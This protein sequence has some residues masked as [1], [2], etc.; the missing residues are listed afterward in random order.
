M[1]KLY[2]RLL[3]VPSLIY[4]FLIALVGLLLFL[5]HYPL[6]ILGDLIRFSFPLLVILLIII[7]AI[8][9]HRINMLH[10]SQAITPQTPVEVQLL[11][12][13]TQ[14]RQS[15]KHFKQKQALHQREQLERLELFAHEIKN[16]LAILKS[17]A[18]NQNQV[19]STTVKR[20]VQQADYYLTL[21]LTDERLAMNA[22]DFTFQWINLEK[23]VNE[24]LQQNSSRFISKQLLPNLTG[25][26][27][28][29]ILSDQKWLRFCITQV[30][31][32][33][34]KYSKTNST[35][36]ITWQNHQLLIADKGCGISPQDLPRV[37]DNGF[38]GHNGHLRTESTG[39]GLY[40]VKKVATKL[41][42]TV[43]INSQVNQGTQVYLSFPAEN[44][45]D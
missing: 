4:L 1:N 26:Q 37:F 31:S 34:I 6:T 32:N 39:M 13:L 35:I 43:K 44:T 11:T 3:L 28:V 10:H 25:L 8:S 38:T 22:N 29:K 15:S 2:L 36:M 18:E 9:H 33:A 5:Y 7:V 21:L 24:I 16:D 12:Q 40:L 14:V 30:L 17:V 42:F 19:A 23:L 45:R 41:N 20:A 27:H